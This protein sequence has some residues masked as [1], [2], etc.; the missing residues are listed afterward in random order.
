MAE[1]GPRVTGTPGAERAREY[2][3]SQLEALGLE[4]QEEELAEPIQAN[5]GSQPPRNLM[6][7]IPGDSEDLIMLAAPYDSRSFDSFEFLGVNDGASGTALLLEIA[8]VLNE[9][10]LPYT[11]MLLFLDAES[12]F[13][14]DTSDYD[15]PRLL[16]SQVQAFKFLRQGMVPRIRLLVAF[17]RVCDPDLVMARDLASSRLYREQFWGSAGK[18]GHHTVFPNGADFETLAGSHI[19]FVQRGV[20]N[21]VF[22]SDSNHGGGESP[23]AFS[24]SEDDNLENCDSGSLQV[25]GDVTLAALD[26]I[27]GR[28]VKVDRVADAPVPPPEAMSGTEISEASDS[29]PEDPVGEGDETV[30]STLEEDTRALLAPEEP[31]VGDPP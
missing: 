30:G 1:I 12:R 7:E 15:E 10:P 27:V 19:A 25:V 11:T 23:G 2:I 21:A 13:G 9:H 4:V 20:R 28:M 24:N 22:L 29:T 17:N 6:V 3:R 26:R 8:R 5:P 18:L 14:E 31:L 16:G